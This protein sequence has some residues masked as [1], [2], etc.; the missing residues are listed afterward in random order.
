[1]KPEKAL[2]FDVITIDGQTPILRII[3]EDKTVQ[4]IEIP[5]Y[6]AL[7]LASQLLDAVPLHKV[8]FDAEI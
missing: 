1:M 5:C 4:N 6:N 3:H 7:I 2:Y 8:K